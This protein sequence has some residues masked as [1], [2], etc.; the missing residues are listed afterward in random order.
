M[1]L[2]VIDLGL[3]DY[4]QAWDIQKDILGEVI[5]HDLAAALILCRHHPVITLGRNTSGS[6]LKFTEEEI[7]AKGLKLYN[8]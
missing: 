5:N 6:S 8:I 2:K 1:N 4:L 7:L 3:A